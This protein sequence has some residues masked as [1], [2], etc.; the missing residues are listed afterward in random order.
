MGRQ[1]AGRIPARHGGE[2]FQRSDASGG[3]VS[4][5]LHEAHG[6]VV[7]LALVA[8]R[9]L[10][11]H[12]FLEQVTQLRAGNGTGLAVARRH[13]IAQRAGAQG[14]LDAGLGV[15]GLDVADLVADHIA[16]FIVGEL[17]HQTRIHPDG[18]VGH[19]KGVD[20][21]R[22]VDLEVHLEAVVGAQARG[23]FGQTLGIGVACRSHLVLAVHLG[24]HLVERA[25]EFLVRQAL[26]LGQV[27]A[28]IQHLAQVKLRPH[29]RYGAHAGSQG[30]ERQQFTAVHGGSLSDVVSF[31]IGLESMGRLCFCA[32]NCKQWLA[33]AEG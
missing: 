21:G 20:L 2:F 4:L 27:L 7:S 13:G 8:L 29:G 1:K 28:C 17:V 23:K 12:H 22:E 26:G 15:A 18:A 5:G 9:M 6:V 16:H 24:G 31:L 25:L 3:L 10:C 33:R 30:Y 32:T 11:A 14:G 19:G